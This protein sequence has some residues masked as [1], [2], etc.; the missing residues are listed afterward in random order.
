MKKIFHLLF[1]TFFIISC[2]KSDIKKINNKI[3][4][5]DNLENRIQDLE[6]ENQN[7]KSSLENLEYS[8][9]DLESENQNL[10]R[11]INSVEVDLYSVEN[12]LSNHKFFDH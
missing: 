3:D 10:K 2:N 6:F 12:D 9:Q 11:K 4:S 8:I 5:L 7:L 1:F